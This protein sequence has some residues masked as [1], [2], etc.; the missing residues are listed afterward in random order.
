MLPD[1]AVDGPREPQAQHAGHGGE[2]AAQYSVSR[3]ALSSAQLRSIPAD[4]YLTA[5]AL[6]FSFPTGSPARHSTAIAPVLGRVARAHSVVAIVELPAARRT[7]TCRRAPAARWAW[8]ASKSCTRR[9]PGQSNLGLTRVL[10]VTVEKKPDTEDSGYG[11]RTGTPV[12]LTPM[13]TSSLRPTRMLE[14]RA[15]L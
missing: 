4:G 2:Q 5:R 1:I 11:G 15:K 6:V 9:L 7:S 12:S 13:Q 8:S 14:R 3:S 10:N